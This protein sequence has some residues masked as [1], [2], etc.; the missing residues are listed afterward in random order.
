MVLACI[1]PILVTGGS[2]KLAL[3][4]YQ[5]CSTVQPLSGLH[6]LSVGGSFHSKFLPCCNRHFCLFSDHLRAHLRERSAA[7]SNYAATSRGSKDWLRRAS[8]RAEFWG[9]TAAVRVCFHLSVCMFV[10]AFH[11]KAKRDGASEPQEE[12]GTFN[13]ITY[14]Q[15]EEE[16]TPEM[17]AGLFLQQ[18]RD[19]K[20]YEYINSNSA[21]SQR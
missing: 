15:R 20:S 13:W 3:N 21:G 10:C 7:R 12:R 6:A 14:I 17:P 9:A 2:L 19:I 11:C 5:V 18:P 4:S 1:Q 8:I 16:K